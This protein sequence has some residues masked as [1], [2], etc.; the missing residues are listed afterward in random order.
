MLPAGSSFQLHFHE[1]MQEVFVLIKGSVEMR[2]GDA[3]S[4]MNAGDTI[5]V[6]PR[7]QHQ[8]FNIGAHAAEYLVFGISSGQNGRTVVVHS[9]SK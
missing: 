3:I 7:E 5:I 2:C 4:Q 8:M 6:Q 9:A 1:D